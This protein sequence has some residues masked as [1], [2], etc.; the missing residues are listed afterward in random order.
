MRG[1][2][3]GGDQFAHLGHWAVADVAVA[4]VRRREAVYQ[5]A[6]GK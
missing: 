2:V 1:L 4:Y 5:W 6:V 3:E